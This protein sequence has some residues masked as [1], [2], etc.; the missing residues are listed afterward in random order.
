MLKVGGVLAF[1]IPNSWLTVSGYTA[2]RDWILRAFELVEITNVWKVFEDVNNDTSILI[3]RKRPAHIEFSHAGSPEGLRELRV[4]AVERGRSESEKLRQL[5]EGTWSIEHRTTHDFQYRQTNHRFEVIYPQRAAVELDQIAARC[6]RLDTIADVT[7]GIQVYHHT[8]VSKDFIKKR[9]FHSTTKE[10]SDWYPFIDANDVQRYYAKASTTQWLHFSSKL[11][12]KRDLAH[13]TEPR[14]LVQQ[15]FWR[16]LCAVLQTSA[17]PELYLNTL[18]SVSNPRDITLACIL[19]FLNSRFVTGSYERR[20]NRLFGD[21]FPKVSKIDLASVPIPRMS[22]KATLAL[23]TAALEL[24]SQWQGLRDALQDANS[25]LAAA[26]PEAGLTDFGHF[27]KLSEA[28]FL[29]RSTRT[30]RAPAITWKRFGPQR[31]QEGK[32][33][34]RHSLACCSFEGGGAGVIGEA[35]V[36]R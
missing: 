23:G 5:A 21:K 7:V 16:R 15:I 19:A 35:C 11:R 26:Y 9:G 30:L 1:I 24:Q 29:A 33:G 17:A 28:E 32:D 20:A 14:I 22:A 6:R 3:A 8:K 36:S 25:D 10:G 4:R 2:F 27:W 12:D 34:G 31:L 13:Y 18:F